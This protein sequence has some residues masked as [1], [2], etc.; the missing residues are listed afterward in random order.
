[1]AAREYKTTTEADIRALVDQG[2]T[3]VAV[4]QRL[5]VNLPSLR[6]AITV[7][8]IKSKRATKADSPRLLG[9]VDR[10]LV[11]DSLQDI[12]ASEGITRQYAHQLLRKHK[13]PSCTRAAVKAKHAPVAQSVEQP[14]CM[15]PVVGSIPARGSTQLTTKAA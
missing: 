8:G 1:M 6:A 11:G 15:V 4:A 7:L 14:L 5:G 3:I 10:L 13:L 12:A 2:L 9:W